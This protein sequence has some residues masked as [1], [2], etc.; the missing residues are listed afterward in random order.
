MS[1]ISEVERNEAIKT[2]LE[3]PNGLKPGDKIYVD[4]SHVSKSGMSRSIRAFILYCEDGKAH[5][6]E[7]T[8]LVGKI[9]G[10]P[11]DQ[12][13]GGV[14]MGGCGMDMGF[15]LVYQLGRALF[16]TGFKLAPNQYGRNGNKSGYD[17]DGG[18][19]L[20]REWI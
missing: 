6:W 17:N 10:A 9:I 7:I 18:Y 16:P 12:K 11:F 8:R 20:Q 19:S 15:E 3:G 14:K 13:H 2:L 4:V 5:R 1:K